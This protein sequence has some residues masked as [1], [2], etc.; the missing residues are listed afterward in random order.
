MQHA[1]GTAS[2]EACILIVE[3]D[4]LVASYIC[5]VL[6]A[7]RF[8]VAGIAASPWEAVA[9]ARQCRPDLALVDARLAGASDG[10]D[11][12]RLLQAEFGVS[13][14][15][16]NAPADTALEAGTDDARAA[17]LLAPP[18]RPSSAL[19]AIE[20]ALETATR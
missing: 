5:Q 17:G 13:S 14:I 15:F 8:V 2:D 4:P 11:V 10:I 1:D 6:T 12:A 3:R 9:L 20:S 18:F 19:R 16:V 7:L